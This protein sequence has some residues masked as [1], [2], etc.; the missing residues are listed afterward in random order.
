VETHKL[1][2]TRVG[3]AVPGNAEQTVVAAGAEGVWVGNVD[4]AKVYRLDRRTGKVSATVGTTIQVAGIAVGAGSVWA[5]DP[6]NS[7]VYRIE[8]GIAGVVARPS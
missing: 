1:T 3:P 8:P 2:M 5:A 7:V 4:A 6:A